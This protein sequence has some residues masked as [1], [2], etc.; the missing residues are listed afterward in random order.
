[1]LSCWSVLAGVEDVRVVT[2]FTASPPPGKLFKGGGYA[3][4]LVSLSPE[5]RTRKARAV[6]CY[7]G[8]L[9]K[10][11]SIYGAFA[12]PDHLEHELYWRPGAVR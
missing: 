6:A 2:V 5:K 10:L 8:E 9:A 1:V 7:A 12:A 11:E 3:A 4:E